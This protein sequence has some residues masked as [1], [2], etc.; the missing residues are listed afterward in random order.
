MQSPIQMRTQLEVTPEAMQISYVVRNEST[1]PILLLDTHWN[2]KAKAFDPD[3]AL[4][5]IRGSKALI[6]R[7]METKP[8]GLMIEHPP[9]PYGREVAPGASLEGKFSVPFP[10]TAFNPYDFYVMPG[11]TAREVDVTDIGF[12]LAWTTV[13]PEPVDRSMAKL[14]RDGITLQPFTYYFLDGKQRFLTSEPVKVQVKGIVKV[15]LGK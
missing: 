6:K 9:V 1:E 2:R 12:M 14:V 11:A 15:P 3:W 10:L 8:K 5:E 7:I 4:V 13:P